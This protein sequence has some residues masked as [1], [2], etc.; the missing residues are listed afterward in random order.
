M[1]EILAI[2]WLYR[3]LKNALEHKNR[4]TGL[5]ALGPVFWVV[6]EILGAVFG[7]LLIGDGLGLYGFAFMGALVGALA[8]IGIVSSVK[9]VELH[10]PK[11]QR[12]FLPRVGRPVSSLKCRGCDAPLRVMGGVVK[13]VKDKKKRIGGGVGVKATAQDGPQRCPYC[14]TDVAIEEAVACT[15]CM[16]RHH[17]ECW[18]SHKECASCGERT[19]FVGVEE[20]E[21]RP[22]KKAPRRRAKDR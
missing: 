16:A 4:S 2:I 15:R 19:R 21:G 14:H 7:A 5:A 11:C 20:T 17:D 1:L 13:V 10:C 3:Y 18:D 8:A 22:K 12:G 6:G 9:P